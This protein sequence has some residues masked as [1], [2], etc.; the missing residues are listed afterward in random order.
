MQA[1]EFEEGVQS[2]ENLTS[3]KPRVQPSASVSKQWAEI[4]SMIVV[5]WNCSLLY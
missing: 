4:L 3:M 2:R 1:Y 5:T